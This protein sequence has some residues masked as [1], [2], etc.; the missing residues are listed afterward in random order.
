MKFAVVY[1]ASSD[2]EMAQ[3]L[4]DRII[5][6]CVSWAEDNLNALRGWCDRIPLQGEITPLTWTAIGRAAATLNIRIHGHFDGR[7]GAPD[8]ASARRALHVLQRTID[9]NAIFLIRDG[10][11]QPE[12]RTGLQQARDGFKSQRT[13]VVIGLANP[14]REAWVLA[15]FQ[16]ADEDEKRLLEIERKN[17]GFD[18][19]RNSEKLTAGSDNTAKLSPKRVLTELVK[20][21]RQREQDCWEKTPLE[22]LRNRG[23]GNGLY[24]YLSEIEA[25]IVPLFTGRENVK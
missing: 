4:A 22:V 24:E 17:L 8:A 16:P 6:H 25:R 9:P 23:D 5:V 15:G 14:E 2:C 21:S 20:G 10:D 18:P 13:T 7:P 19:T 12:R 3:V 1:E 11:N